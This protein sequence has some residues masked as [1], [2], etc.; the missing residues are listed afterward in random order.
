MRLSVIFSLVLL[1]SLKTSAQRVLKRI[2]V[3]AGVSDKL[4]QHRKSTIS[5]IHYDLK[6]TIPSQ[7]QQA[8]TA[9]ESIVLNL[10]ENEVSLQID[11][12]EERDHLNTLLVNG[13][14]VSIVFINE[15]IVIDPKFLKIGSN[16]IA[17]NFTAGNLS[18]NRNE[19]FLYT[20]L[21]PDRA[22]TVF[23]CFDQPDLKATFNLSLTIPKEWNALS[24]A[25]LADSSIAAGNKTFNFV[26]SD[27][28]STYLF[29][30]VAGKFGSVTKNVNGRAMNFYHR[31]TDTNKINFSTDSIFRIHGDALNFLE[32]YTQISYPFKKFDFVGIPDFQYGGMEHVGAIDYKASSLFLD[33]GATKDQEN[34]R[35]NLIAHEAS[36][37][38]FGNL[39]TM[40]WFNDV[41]MKEVF[42]N[43][44]ADKVSQAKS[45]YD[46]K[47]LI[48]HFPTAYGVD[49]TLG[50]NPIRQQL[51]NL[52]EAGTLYGNIIYH[53]APIMMRQLERLMG[54][55]AFRD[56]LREYLAKY[57]FS[58]ATWP[59]LI[60]ILDSRT[61]ADLNTWNKVWV[62]EAGRPV[63]SYRLETKNGFISKLTISQQGEYVP[64]LIL[65][66][67][68]EIAL[69]YADTVEEY[70]VE[71][72]NSQ[73]VLE[74]VKGRPRPLFI[75]FNSS[76][77][78]YG[79]FPIE[80]KMLD[81]L[82][83]LKNPVMRATA[84]INLYENMLSRKGIKPMQLLGLYKSVL[85]KEAEELNLRLITN[86]ISDIF[87]RL[88]LPAKRVEI[89]RSLEQKLWQAMKAE[90][91]ANK[92]KL[93]FK[94][95]QSI[96]L[97]E[98]AKDTLYKVWKDEKAPTG[99]K[100]TEDDYTSLALTLAV[101]N[102]RAAGILERQLTRIKN[103]DRRN[104]L[105]YL[106]TPLSNDAAKR[107]AFFASLKDEKNRDKE[108]WV[109]T[110]LDYLHHP[111][112]SG[113][114]KKYLP[115]SLELL[116]QIQLTGDIFF[117]TAWLQST[118]GSYQ[119][120]E[121][122]NVVRAFLKTHPNYHPGLKAK[123]LQA[124][125]PLFRAEKIILQK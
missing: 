122:A 19:D 95:F 54:K 116:Q 58:N 3:E 2:A 98:P 123:I 10:S 36:H 108:A 4:A 86:H 62:N 31:E 77:Q 64:K 102:Y 74:A 114:S 49:R 100:L 42:A 76:G 81:H 5:K 57:K 89:G 94:T 55:D 47:F 107:D 50:A 75:L 78:G 97:T 66:Q 63:I 118:F 44:M 80:N 70:T 15:H 90:T 25:P 1:M 73:L 8:I 84:F 16:S 101:K 92:K 113:T 124:A 46:L 35:A 83:E 91:A 40:H 68:F 37:I 48:D 34:A 121:A 13:K 32:E 106:M 9:S 109:A 23:P 33:Q 125:D 26:Q 30:F 60:A 85:S 105:A 93:L 22:R 72:N 53:K 43:F 115:Q 45:N 79:L 38:W 27:T 82:T 56:G 103:V 17:I 71:L 24:N 88:I 111:L 12:K 7:K 112:R 21:V 59:D 52:Q 87:W 67:L 104:R 96:A 110:A 29:S 11:F 61:K 51:S 65:P 28:I 119:S 18:L 41:W 69:V 14:D 117:P 120:P 39:V 99:V 6:L 20:L